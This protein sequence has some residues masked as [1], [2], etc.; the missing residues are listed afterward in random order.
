MPLSFPAVGIQE[1]SLRLKRSVAVTSSPFTFDQQVFAHQGAVWQAE[2][3]LPPLTHDDARAVEAFIA[4]L[5]GRTGTFT[6]GHP[7][8]TS[9]ATSTTTG[10]AAVR[11]ETL[12][13]TVGSSAVTAGTYFQ[14]GDYLYIVTADKA[15]G[16]GSLEFQPPLRTAVTTGTVLDFTLP[17]SLWRLVSNDIGWSTDVAS[18]Y[19]FSFAFTEAL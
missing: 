15:S 10:T 2:V 7:L 4:G 14:L 8:H 16:A 13:T 17:K 5:K 6:F 3:T 19:G 18:L 1:I 9:S 12:T 11:A